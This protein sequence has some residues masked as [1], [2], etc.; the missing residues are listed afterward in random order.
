MFIAQFLR[1]NWLILILIGGLA[2]A[3]LILRTQGTALSSIEEF[4]QRVRS[5]RP[6]V[7]EIYSNT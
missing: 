6:I 5:G 1:E 7:V 3:W 2:A 4:D